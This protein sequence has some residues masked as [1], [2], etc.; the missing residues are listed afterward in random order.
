MTTPQEALQLIADM[1][2][3]GLRADDLGRAA[4][5]AR[6]A[7]SQP[8][9]QPAMY[10]YGFHSPFDGSAVWRDS[11]NTWNGQQPWCAE[12]LYAAPARQEA[13][14]PQSIYA[15]TWEQREGQE[16]REQPADERKEA[17]NELKNARSAKVQGDFA[18][19]VEFASCRAASAFAASVVS[20][21]AEKG[22][23]K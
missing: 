23:K 10:R 6:D 20:A 4:R 11:P 13:E 2:P 15:E 21:L 17:T 1:D 9:P 18:V 5:I 12:P 16:P 22:E 3:E 7:L 19:L 14:K 8:A